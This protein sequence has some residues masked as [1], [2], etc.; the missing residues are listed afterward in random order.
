MRAPCTKL[1]E[2]NEILY[3]GVDLTYNHS[4]AM[5][6]V[7][8]STPLIDAEVAE[9]DRRQPLGL[10]GSCLELEWNPMLW[11]LFSC[12]SLCFA[13]ARALEVASHPLPDSACIFSASSMRDMTLRA[14]LV[15]DGLVR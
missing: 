11:R 1:H 13:S 4:P 14:V 12:K 2:I 8:I 6:V 3:T 15:S 5:V 9:S 10:D 7:R